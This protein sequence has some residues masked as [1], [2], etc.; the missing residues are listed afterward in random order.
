[1]W[2]AVRRCLTSRYEE[3]SSNMYTSL[4]WTATAAMANLCSSPPDRTRISRFNKCFNS[5]WV[6]A[7]SKMSL[8]SAS[9]R[10]SFALRTC[11]TCPL[12]ARGM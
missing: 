4:T 5:A 12:M 6:V 2:A 7:Q 3:G 10:S 9:L 1:M 11:S 8:P